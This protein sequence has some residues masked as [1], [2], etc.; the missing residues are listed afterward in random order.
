MKGK[1]SNQQNVDNMEVLT[2]RVFTF[3]PEYDPAEMRLS[4][5]NQKRI[6]ASSDEVLFGVTT[7][8]SACN[9][10][11]SARTAAFDALDP[12]ITCVINALRISEV[13]EQTIKQ[14]ESIVREMR[15]KRASVI[16]H[17]ISAVVGT[18]I[19]E[20]AKTNKIHGSSYNTRIEN[21][22]RLIVLLGTI[23]AYKPKETD[24]TVE[25][26]N[27]RLTVLTR[28]NSALKT[29]DAQADAARTQRDTILYA[30]KTGLVDIA[31][32]SKLYV[33]SAYGA[34]SPQYKSI[35]GIIFSRL[36]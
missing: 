27:N 13:S 15:H 3:Q 12:L 22:R 1:R 35:S 6:K 5:P 16:T 20:P 24:L 33:K 17:V 9:N 10:A 34:S 23:A 25:M 18:E 8:E 21:F 32:D 4:I 36:R 28:L 2:E 26:L 14:G 30:S 31:M 11:I 19:N 29:A 7:A